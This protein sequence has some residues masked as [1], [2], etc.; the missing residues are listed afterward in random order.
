MK[1]TLSSFE[2]DGI[3]RGGDVKAGC[4]HC[5]SWIFTRVS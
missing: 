1:N 3:V 4:L 2:K 5:L